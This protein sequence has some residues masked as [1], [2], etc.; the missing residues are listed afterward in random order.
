MKGIKNTTEL[1]QTGYVLKRDARELRK[2]VAL[3]CRIL[4]NAGIADYLGHISA[5]I[6]GANH[7][8][9]RARGSEAGSM[10]TTSTKQILAVNFDG[11]PLKNELSLK[12]PIETPIHTRILSARKDVTSVVHVHAPTPIA[13]SLAGLPIL[14]IFNQG[15]ELAIEGIPVYPK[16]GLIST[17]ERGDELAATLGTKSSC[18]LLAHG[19]VTVGRSIEEATVRAL[20][21]E[22]IARMNLSA[23]L[24]GG[25]KAVQTGNLEIDKTRVEMEIR[26]EWKYQMEMLR[27][28]KAWKTCGSL[29]P[30]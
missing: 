27:A 2:K 25:P 23:R 7:L 8:L 29:L 3:A 26:G 5:R 10:L 17:P 19:I 13:F 18:I 11:R 6:P 14:P 1:L 21:L 4:G 12:P 15:M 20:R 28:T 9:I 22:A 30:P 16:N 24:L